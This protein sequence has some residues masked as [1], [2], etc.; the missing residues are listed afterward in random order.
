MKNWS[1]DKVRSA[2]GTAAERTAQAAQ[3]VGAAVVQVRASVRQTSGACP[4]GACAGGWA[5]APSSVAHACLALNLVQEVAGAKCLLDY[6]VGAQV[7]A[8]GP[9]SLWRVLLAHAKKEGEETRGEV[10]AR[11]LACAWVGGGGRRA[12]GGAGGW[13]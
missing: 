1:F 13:G 2:L 4:A 8:A 11:V 10:H 7:A 6:S 5:A 9:A 3:A 12:A